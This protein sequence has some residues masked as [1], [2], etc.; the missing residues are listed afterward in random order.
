[1][2]WYVFDEVQIDDIYF[3]NKSKIE[4][5]FMWIP[6]YPTQTDLEAENSMANN[7]ASSFLVVELKT[8]R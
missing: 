2:L 7:M 4:G 8:I 6:F 1:M 5:I 3:S